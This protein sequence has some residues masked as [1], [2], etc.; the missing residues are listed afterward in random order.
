MLDYLM[1]ADQVEREAKR[2]V[3]ERS[4]W[5]LSSTKVQHFL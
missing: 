1:V 5:N 3:I 4:S 2:L